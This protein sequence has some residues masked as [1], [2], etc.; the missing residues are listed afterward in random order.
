MRSL[1]NPGPTTL[2]ASLGLLVLRL[3]LGGIM[4]IGHGWS[5][6]ANFSEMSSKFPDLLGIGSTAN[7]ALAIGAELVC[8]ALV[9][10]GLFTRVAAVPLMFT[11]IMAAFVVHGADPFQKKELALL[12]LAGFTTLAFTGAGRFSVDGVVEG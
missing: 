3:T 7:L 5:K 4:A 2:W 9:A 12:Y 1:M 10:V 8:A 11:M 6:L